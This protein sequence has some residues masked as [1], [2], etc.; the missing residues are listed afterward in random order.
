MKKEDRNIYISNIDLDEA[1]NVYFSKI[2]FNFDCYDEIS[3]YDSLDRITVDSIFAKNSSPHYNSAA[4]DGIA[5]ISEN[6]IGASE[7]NPKI[8]EL[9]KDFIY[10]NTGNVIGEDYNSVIMIEDVMEL[11]DNKVQII[12]PSYPWQHIR[13]IGEDIVAGEMILSSNHKIRPMDIAALICGGISKLKV[14]KKPIVSI[15]PTG[16]EIIETIDD[17]EEGK[18]IDTNSRVFENLVNKYGGIPNRYSPQED[19]YENLKKTIDEASKNSDIVVVNAGTSAGSK[20]YIVKVIREIGEVVVHGIALKPGKPT[21]LGLVNNKPVV[22]IPG[23]PVSA[24]IV[25]EEVVKRIILK[26]SGLEKEKEDTYDAILSKRLV[27]S[28]KNKE[29]VRVNLGYVEGKLVATPLTRGAGVTM[30]LVKAD[31]FIEIP[32]NTEGVEAGSTVKVRLLKPINQI[33]NA[34]VSIGSHDIVM[35]IIAN[36]MNLSSGHVGSMGGVMAIKR[37]EAHIAPIHLLDSNTGEYNISYVK[38]YFK[39]EKMILIKGVKRLQG[40]IVQKGNPKNIKTFTDL[41]R[42]DV[43]YINRQRGAGTRLLLDYNLSKLNIEIDDIMGYEREM[44]THMAVA[45]TVKSESA[46]TGLGIMSVAKAMDLDFIP[47]G[48]ESYDFLL[49]ES[50]LKDEKI[51]S[52]INILK[53]ENFK[54]EVENLEGYEFDNTGEVI[55]I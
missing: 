21:I 42:K 35:D 3:V 54:N 45:V 22:G 4:M 31:G 34:L 47:V 37:N 7:I 29:V 20:D 41:K 23:Y 6:T 15:I 10:V 49:K 5:V 32:R 38:K 39:D 50:N 1:I 12:S 44:N 14:L 17:I 36:K 16:N 51:K 53:S 13:P 11:E 28:L 33:K 55:Y 46:D 52:F 48:Y 19:D 24:Y 27:S 43:C 30:S 9:N 8:L 2:N 25:F 18:I 40:F 26:F